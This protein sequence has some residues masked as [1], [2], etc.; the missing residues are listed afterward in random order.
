MSEKVENPRRIRSFVLRTG[1]MTEGQSEA[2]QQHW[3]KYGLELADGATTPQQIFGREVRCVLE[4]GFGMGDSLLQMAKDAPDSDFIGIEVHTP[5]VGRLLA[6]AEADGVNNLRVFRE[7]AVR[8]LEEVLPDASLDCVQLFFPDPWP[9]KRH[10]KRRLVQ[11]EF[12]D[13]LARKLKAGGKLHVATDW[14]PYAEH[15]LEV[16]KLRPEWV[17]IAQEGDFVPRPDFRPE[18]KFERRGLKLGHGVW[19]M[20]FAV[21]K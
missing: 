15:C 21:E 16:F 12:L 20:I 11:P 1:R 18:T 6:G 17:N 19:D 14:E 7:D 3:G 8:V 10:H 2:F 5:G 13:L 9:K 4:I